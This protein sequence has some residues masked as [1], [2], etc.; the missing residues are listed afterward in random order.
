MFLFWGACVIWEEWEMQVSAYLL[1]S[2]SD[3]EASNPCYLFPD[4]CVLYCSWRENWN[5]GVQITDGQ[6]NI[7]GYH[8]WKP[9]YTKLVPWG[10]MGRKTCAGWNLYWIATVGILFSTDKRNFFFAQCANNLCN[11]LSQDVV[12]APGLSM[13]IGHIYGGNV[14]LRLQ[15]MVYHI[16]IQP[17]NFRSTLCTCVYQKFCLEVDP[18][19]LG[20]MLL[21]LLS[22]AAWWGAAPAK[23]PS[24]ILCLKV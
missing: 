9:G 20:V 12:M 4:N 13:R 18:E 8:F 1:G 17:L 19:N 16:S 11:A 22:T 24:S 23:V 5:I 3:M 7:A 10:P 6:S 2:K 14:R 15:V 21:Q